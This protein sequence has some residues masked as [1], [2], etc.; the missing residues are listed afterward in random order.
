MKKLIF[1]AIAASSILTVSAFSQ[2]SQIE[3]T[4]TP[5]HLVITN[6]MPPIKPPTPRPTPTPIVVG[7]SSRTNGPSAVGSPRL[8]ASDPAGESS[9]F[10]SASA[11]VTTL[12][13]GMIKSRIAEAKRQMQSRPLSTAIN[14]SVVPSDFVRV[15][16]LD[17]KTHK[18]DYAVMTKDAF[19]SVADEKQTVSENGRRVTF[20]T[21][22]GNG[23]NTPLSIID[24]NGVKHTPLLVQYP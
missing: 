7:E 4:P 9:N 6:S 18:I 21:I 17:S 23:V 5:V 19:L 13:F 11:G 2:T 1:C 8:A 14:E 10:N 3:P 20:R 24:E 22:R 12:S 15:A 16:F